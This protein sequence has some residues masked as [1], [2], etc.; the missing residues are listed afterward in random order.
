[1]IFRYLLQTE[2]KRTL[3][4]L[5]LLTLSASIIEVGSLALFTISVSTLISED[6]FFDRNSFLLR[7]SEPVIVVLFLALSLV[8]NQI[9]RYILVKK[10]NQIGFQI[11][12]DLL[13]G[14]LA[15]VIDGK[16]SSSKSNQDVINSVLQ[17]TIRAKNYVKALFSFISSTVLLLISFFS[18]AFYDLKIVLIMFSI[19][20][21]FYI[22]AFLVQKSALKKIGRRLTEQVW[23]RSLLGLSILDSIREIIIYNTYQE[24]ME[25]FGSVNSDVAK[26]TAQNQF[27]QTVPG[28]ILKA[29][30]LIVG[31]VLLAVGNS[32]G[33]LDEKGVL[34]GLILVGVRLLGPAQQLSKTAAQLISDRELVHSILL[35]LSGEGQERRMVEFSL[36]GA[37]GCALTELKFERNRIYRLSGGSGAGKSTFADAILGFC[38]AVNVRF[39]FRME[40]SIA[41]LRRQEKFSYVSQTPFIFNGTVAENLY[42]SKERWSEASSLLER[43]GLSP[44]LW[45]LDQH[46][47]NEGAGWNLS[48][49]EAQRI[50]IARALLA[51]REILIFDEPTS[52]LDKESTLK[53]I[54]EIEKIKHRSVVIIITHDPILM[55]IADTEIRV[56]IKHAKRRRD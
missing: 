32:L 28:E 34:V 37:N 29:A 56:S 35:R 51:N 42:V 1:M 14:E 41:E 9:Y 7:L 31:L 47:I 38:H 10:S 55:A 53:F 25:K 6:S 52:N 39:D 13:G 50:S 24:M 2:T 5:V 20:A 46:V 22:P 23:R 33:S 3:A 8:V 12:T 19:I 44:A 4:G 21:I 30:F 40:N 54:K 45:A 48:G 49:G 17:E 18:V 16:Y 26:T 27:F 43:L 15:A 36:T 11:G